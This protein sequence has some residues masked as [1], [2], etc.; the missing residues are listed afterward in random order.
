MDDLAKTEEDVKLQGAAAK[1][2]K[3]FVLYIMTHIAH[4]AL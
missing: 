4:D 3:F 2:R 1:T